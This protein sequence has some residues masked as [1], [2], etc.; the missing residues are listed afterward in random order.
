MSATLL[1]AEEA[2]KANIELITNSK[3]EHAV[4]EVVVAMQAARRSGSAN[5]KTKGE[6]N[7]SGRKPWRQKGTGRARAG[8][9]ASPIWRGGGVVFGPKPRDYSKKVS[10]SSRK[11]AFRKAFSSR[12]LAGDVL[13]VDTFAVPEPKTKQFLALLGEAVK[14]SRKIL[15]VGTS[16]DETTLLAARNVEKTQ[17][18]RA[19][20]L[21]TE[22]LLRYDKIVVTREALQTISERLA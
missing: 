3:G 7:K 2:K 12:V 22:Q 10:K 11:L 8:N 16:F 17:L 21:N 4:H 9:F 15:V 20:D 5:T 19:A 13:V 14:E 1:S 18:S 6:V